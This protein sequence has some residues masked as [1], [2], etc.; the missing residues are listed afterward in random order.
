MSKSILVT[1]GA[2]YIG[3]HMVRV[4]LA[5]GYDVTVYDNL[6]LGHRDA[7]GDA[8]LVVGDI[9]DGEKLAGVCREKKIDA[10]LHFAAFAQVGESVTQPEKYFRNNTC[11]SLS[12]M[13]AMIETGVR[14]FVLSSTAAVYGEPEKIPIEEGDRELPT[15]PY[16]RSKLFV[17]KILADMRTAH[18]LE[19]VS[20]RYFNAAGADPSG[21]IGEDHEP[22]S[23][24]IPLVLEA[25]AGKRQNITVFG[26]DYDTPD[27]SCVR[28]YIHVNDL[29]EAHVLALEWM[30]EGN[31]SRIYNLGNGEGYS[32]R[33]V[34]DVARAVTGNDIP[35][36][37]GERRAGDPAR[38]VASSRKIIDELG[39][40]P[41]FGELEKIIE[42]AWNWHKNHPQG[43]N[44]R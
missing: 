5:R 13:Q 17:E 20:L 1:G 18:G 25:A 37:A 26:D 2:G 33:E 42:T 29:A 16:G 39:F 38:L 21:K 35:V 23:H 6:S 8:Q 41:R 36:V 43:Y 22:E 9:G 27:G 32:V 34:I 40:S 12:I 44:D 30:F 7:V 24:L 15:N 31:P 10:V 28:D 3:S 11:G 4:L 19:S 14:N